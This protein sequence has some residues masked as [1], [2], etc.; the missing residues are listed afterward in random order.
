M[1]KETSLALLDRVSREKQAASPLEVFHDAATQ[2]LRQ[3]AMRDVLHTALFAGGMGAAAGGGVGLYNLLRRNLAKRKRTNHL[4]EMPI[5]VPA[6]SVPGLAKAAGWWGEL[7]AG[8]LAT[9]KEGIPWYRPAQA[10]AGIGAGVGSF[11]LVDKL[12]KYRRR[13]DQE[14]EVNQAKSQFE[15][16]LAENQGAKLASDTQLPALL[17]RLYDQLEKAAG[18]LDSVLPSN[19]TLGSVLGAYGAYA[20]PLALVSGYAAY[21]TANKNSQRKVLEK[22]LKLRSQRRQALQPAELVAKPVPLSSTE[23]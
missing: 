13:K 9:G 11:A 20:A 7:M 21:K 19:N 16:A 5:G 17:D 15:Q 8:K 6:D 10:A 23:E 4:T 1:D 18:I 12:L 14:A 3:D 22:A 2:P